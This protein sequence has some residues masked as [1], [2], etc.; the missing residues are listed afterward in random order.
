MAAVPRE[1]LAQWN[2]EAAMSPPWEDTAIVLALAR[3]EKEDFCKK[4][5]SLLLGCADIISSS[6]LPLGTTDSDPLLA[7]GLFLPGEHQ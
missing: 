4:L 5:T 3:R 2:E 7:G 6:V 1:P